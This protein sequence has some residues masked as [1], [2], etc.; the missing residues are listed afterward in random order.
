[1]AFVTADSIS[2]DKIVFE[3]R[4][5]ISFL[6]KITLGT[7]LKKSVQDQRDRDSVFMWSRFSIER[8][9]RAPSGELGTSIY[10]ELEYS[11]KT[12]NFQERSSNDFFYMRK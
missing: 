10:A 8:A 3:Y 4:L 6:L 11:L 5:S 2:F 1:M 9:A 7:R 12:Q